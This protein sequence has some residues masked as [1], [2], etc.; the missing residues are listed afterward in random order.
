MNTYLNHASPLC[1][2]LSNKQ[3]LIIVCNRFVYLYALTEDSGFF[4]LGYL[5]ERWVY[6]VLSKCF[7]AWF[8]LYKFGWLD[9]R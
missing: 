8:L 6:V 3:A 9:D 5:E 1:G 4:W 2:I 7:E